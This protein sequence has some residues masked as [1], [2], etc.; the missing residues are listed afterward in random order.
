MFLF[1]VFYFFG[2]DK[3]VSL[4]PMYSL[5]TMRKSDLH[6][7]LRTELWLSCFFFLRLIL[8]ANKSHLRRWTLKWSFDFWKEKIVKALDLW[9]IS[10]FFLWNEKFYELVLFGFFLLI[11]NTFLEITCGINNRLKLT[12]QKKSDYRWSEKEMK[13]YKE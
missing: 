7:S 5:I 9:K 13:M 12:L 10:W 4:A 6:Y 1:N 3:G 8:V 2:V 11:L